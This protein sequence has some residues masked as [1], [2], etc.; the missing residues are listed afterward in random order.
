[1]AA[2]TPDLGTD[3]RFVD[4]KARRANAEAFIAELDEVFKSNSMEHWATRFDEHDVWWSP[5]NTMAEVLEDPQVH[6]SG[7]FVAVDNPD[8]DPIRSV[9]S[10]IT[11]RDAP[12]RQTPP[13]PQVGEHT[14]EVLAELGLDSPGE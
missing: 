8:G 4:A 3:E 5:A 10:P 13:A 6:A 7:G 1:M 2:W 11:F 14:S 9:N 12:L